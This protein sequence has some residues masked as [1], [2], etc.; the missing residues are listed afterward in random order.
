MR[1]AESEVEIEV[2]DDGEAP[3]TRSPWMGGGHTLGG[4]GAS[5]GSSRAPA[6][7]Q[8][9]AT[10]EAMGFSR[11][12]AQAALA[13]VGGGGAERA[14]EWLLENPGSLAGTAPTAPQETAAAPAAAPAAS[15]GDMRAR[16]LARFSAAQPAEPE[17]LD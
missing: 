6:S 3:P 5:A 11:A 4:G 10:I 1:V 9:V 15:A 2:L 7:P 12:Q 13:A 16:R 17:E 8:D 14:V